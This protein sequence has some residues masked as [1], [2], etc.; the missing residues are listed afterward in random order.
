MERDKMKIREIENRHIKKISN[1]FHVENAE[2]K[3]GKKS[4]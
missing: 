2:N 4:S 3:K 1:S